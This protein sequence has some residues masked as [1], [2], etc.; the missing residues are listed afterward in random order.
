MV[1]DH[2]Y[3]VDIM[4]DL[5]PSA[6][7]DGTVLTGLCYHLPS[8]RLPGLKILASKSSVCQQP[9]LL[10]PRQGPLGHLTSLLL[11]N[12]T[13]MCVCMEA[14]GG[15]HPLPFMKLQSDER[16]EPE[17]QGHQVASAFTQQITHTVVAMT[18]LVHKAL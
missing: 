4:P 18:I 2:G 7:A 8:V 10:S 1:S 6:S 9:C 13:R 17:V 12:H 3:H 16:F 11:W 15:G 14:L 5:V